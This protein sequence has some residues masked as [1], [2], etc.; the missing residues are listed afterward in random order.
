[1]LGTEYDERMVFYTVFTNKKG[2]LMNFVTKWLLY[3][4]FCI[5]NKNVAL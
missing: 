1:M 2:T 3:K 4:I 5:C